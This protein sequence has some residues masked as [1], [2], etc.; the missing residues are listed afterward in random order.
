MNLK[1]VLSA[2]VTTLALLSVFSVPAIASGPGD[3]MYWC[4][5]G[6]NDSECLAK[7]QESEYWTTIPGFSQKASVPYTAQLNTTD[8]PAGDTKSVYGWSMNL[9]ARDLT[10]SPDVY[11]NNKKFVDVVKYKVGGLNLTLDQEY[12]ESGWTSFSSTYTGGVNSLFILERSSFYGGMGAD[13]V[14]LNNKSWR[15]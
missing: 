14:V 12:A 8:T 3:S 10:L 6:Q 2:G 7:A 4:G 9:N 1:K 5:D 15:P 11:L 13:D